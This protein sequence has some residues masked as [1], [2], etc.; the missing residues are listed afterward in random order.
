MDDARIKNLR[1]LIEQ[2]TELKQTAELLVSELTEQLPGLFPQQMIVVPDWSGDVTPI[3]ETTAA[4]LPSAAR[5]SAVAAVALPS[6]RRGF[7]AAP[8]I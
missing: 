5:P 8:T 1:A 2:A 6:F 7:C 4:N 3:D